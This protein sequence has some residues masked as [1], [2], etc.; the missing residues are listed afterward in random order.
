MPIY[1]SEDLHIYVVYWFKY[2]SLLERPKQMHP[3]TM[4]SQLA[5]HPLAQANM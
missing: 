3:E 2:Q 1:I 4:F 5:G